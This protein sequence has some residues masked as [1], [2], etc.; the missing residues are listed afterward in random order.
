MS[1]SD[2]EFLLA[3]LLA[4]HAASQQG[5]VLVVVDD[6]LKLKLKETQIMELADQ[7]FSPFNLV[8]E[9]MTRTGVFSDGREVTSILIVDQNSQTLQLQRDED[10]YVAHIDSV[11]DQVI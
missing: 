10:I 7:P 4:L 5:K 8:N 9:V 6:V 1:H 2:S 3:P 11:A